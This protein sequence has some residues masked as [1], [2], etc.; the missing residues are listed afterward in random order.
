MNSHL[1]LRILLVFTSFGHIIEFI[2][3]LFEKA[4]V[5]ATCALIFAIIELFASYYVDECNCEAVCKKKKNKESKK[6]EAN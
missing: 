2:A 3:A 1:I 4:Y 5:T 6:K